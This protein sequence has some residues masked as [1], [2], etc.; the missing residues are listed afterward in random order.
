MNLKEKQPCDSASA[1]LDQS[2]QFCERVEVAIQLL[3]NIKQQLPKLEELLAEVESHWGIED[4]FYR[5]YHQSFKV[6]QVQQTTEEISKTLQNLLPNRPMNEW[7]C[8]IIAEG[9][10]HEFEMSHNRDWLHHTRP[11]LEAF[12]H[13]HFFLKIAIKY[14]KE[15]ERAPDCLPSG[16]AAV[17]YLFNLR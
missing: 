7:F 5:F 12:F 16:W 6:Y 14:G 9:T 4:G 10:G 2:A 15:L 8:K 1:E 17:L 3:S 13:A 11:I